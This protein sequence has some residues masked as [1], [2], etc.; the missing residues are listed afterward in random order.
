MLGR[1]GAA[2]GV[3]ARA[4]ALT[5]AKRKRG[6]RARWPSAT[7]KKAAEDGA[8]PSRVPWSG[9]V[10]G[11]VRANRPRLAADDR[12]R[13]MDQVVVGECLDHEQR[14]V[15]PGVR[16]LAR[17]GSPT[18]RFTRQALARVLLQKLPRITVQRASLAYT[19]RHP[20]LVDALAA[21]RWPVPQ[22]PAR[23]V[24]HIGMRF[25]FGA[26]WRCPR[27]GGGG[28]PRFHDCR[29]RPPREP[30]RPGRPM[31][32]AVAGPASGVPRPSPRM[33]G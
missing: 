9:R 30:D 26:G 1:R 22:A 7:S 11:D 32:S 17:I 2:S 8:L 3:R 10:H 29:G 31:L 18:C 28:D 19:G 6:P 16:L 23:D 12:R 4:A 33:T 24:D 21:W 5:W 25:W 20:D 14:E 15:D 13:L 27:C